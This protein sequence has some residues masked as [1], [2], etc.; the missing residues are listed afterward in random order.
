MLFSKEELDE[1]LISNEQKHENTP[2]ELKGA[3]QRKD[4]LEWMDELKN[5]LKTQFLHESH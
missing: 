3:M 5:E 1:F 2:N 4:F